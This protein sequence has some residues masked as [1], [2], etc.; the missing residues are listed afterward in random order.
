MRVLVSM[1]LLG[2]NCRYNGVP[3]ANEAVVE[4]LSREDITL[5][6][7]CPEQLGGLPTPRTPSEQQGTQ[8]VDEKGIDR[9]EAFE[10]G[11]KEALRIAKL[12]GC[13]AAILKERSPS[14]GSG[15]VYD[16]TFSHTQVPGDG[17]CAGLLKE[18]GIRV[19]GESELKEFYKFYFL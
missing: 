17:V 7:V 18:N 15:L 9:T 3:Q 5:I 13:E 1:C 6:P 11:A 16:G 19:F 4:L 14:C 12:Y 10:S 2:A 8:V